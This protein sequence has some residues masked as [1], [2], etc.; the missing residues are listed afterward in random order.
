MERRTSFGG[1]FADAASLVLLSR[2]LSV[3][4]IN[5]DH[6]SYLST[7]GT[8]EQVSTR[9]VIKIHSSFAVFAQAGVGTLLGRGRPWR[10]A[11]WWRQPCFKLVLL[12]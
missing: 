11:P 5:L 2:R 8:K 9:S 10:G 3:F 6:L 1:C 7:L 4:E 12:V